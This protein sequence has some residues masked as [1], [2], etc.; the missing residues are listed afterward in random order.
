MAFLFASDFLEYIAC[1][2]SV[3]NRYLG[4]LYIFDYNTLSAFK[5]LAFKEDF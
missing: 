3:F 4:F 2:N 5:I 1:L